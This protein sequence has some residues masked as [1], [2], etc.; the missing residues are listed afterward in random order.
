MKIT[1]THY[2]SETDRN[3]ETPKKSSSSFDVQTLSNV[4]RFMKSVFVHL[5][6]LVR[7][8]SDPKGQGWLSLVMHLANSH[9]R[10]PR[11]EDLFR[12]DNTD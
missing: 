2:R 3:H 1:T 6:C 12:Q 5:L 9:V 11:Q 4:V 7:L 8:T 10:N